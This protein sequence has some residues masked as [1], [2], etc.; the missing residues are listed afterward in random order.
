MD[1]GKGFSASSLWGIIPPVP[2][3]FT[4][5]GL[6]DEGAFRG[7]VRFFLGQGVHGLTVGGSTGEGHALS[8]E[9]LRR[10]VETAVEEVAGRVPVIAGII[11]DSTRQAVERG[12]AL[13]HLGVAAL[14]VTPVHY[15]FRPTDDAMVAQFQ[16]IAQYTG[17]PLLIYKVVPR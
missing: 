15:L 12:R 13:A 5:E 14:M 8:T 16:A 1:G 11:V 17:Q 2:T 9:E 3:P 10:L 7:V 6:V 4:V